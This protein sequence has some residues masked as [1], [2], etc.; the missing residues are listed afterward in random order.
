MLYYAPWGSWPPPVWRHLIHMP[1]KRPEVEAE[2][3]CKQLLLF[4]AW[5]KKADI[6][7]LGPRPRAQ[8]F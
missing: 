1:N 5:M 6:C 2:M 4:C 3:K 7:L 8:K